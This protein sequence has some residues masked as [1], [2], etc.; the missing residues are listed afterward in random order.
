MT[1]LYWA[2]ELQQT[3]EESMSEVGGSK[4]D[5]LVGSQLFDQS[6]VLLKILNGTTLEW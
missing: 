2:S 3:Q 6:Q 4:Q 1:C 5:S